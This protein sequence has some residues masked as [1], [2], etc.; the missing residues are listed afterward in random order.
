M[1]VSRE[2]A[3]VAKTLLAVKTRINNIQVT[4]LPKPK[5]QPTDEILE[6]LVDTLKKKGNARRLREVDVDSGNSI[7]R[8]DIWTISGTAID[9]AEPEGTSIKFVV[10]IRGDRP[11][12]KQWEKVEPDLSVEA[13]A[14]V[15]EFERKT[16]VAVLKA[17]GYELDDVEDFEDEGDYF[18]LEVGG[19]EWMGFK[20][21]D[22]AESY[23][24]ER[25]EE[26]LSENP[27][28]F[29]QDWFLGVIDEGKAEALFRGIYD[30]W[31]T[32]YANDIESEPSSEGYDSRL[33]DEL[34]RWGIVDEDD[35][36]D[37]ETGEVKDDWDASE[38]ADELAEKMTQDQIDEGTGGYDH[39]K[40][41]FGDEDAAKLVFDHGLVD[42]SKAAAE[43]VRVDGVAHFLSSYDGNETKVKGT[44]WYRTN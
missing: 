7:M 36:L 24:T 30:E 4:W 26:D 29:N 5:F 22:D 25:V 19:E 35:V 20:S 34:V 10:E 15:D 31:N 41:N 18:R 2:L 44:V 13:E 9:A 3:R 23:A 32:S 38:H 8:R 40:D 16:A 33:T 27:E 21:S 39:Y 12:L 11:K 43:A 37:E 28:I 6:M 17:M 42:I 1:D 14:F